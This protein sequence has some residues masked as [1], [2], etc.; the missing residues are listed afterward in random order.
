MSFGFGSPP[1]GAGPDFSH[2]DLGTVAGVQLTAATATA[3]ELNSLSDGITFADS[4]AGLSLTQNNTSLNFGLDNNV[5]Q[6]GLK[7]QFVLSAGVERG[8]NNLPNFALLGG[9]AAGVNTPM[10]ATSGSASFQ[11]APTAPAATAAP[12]PASLTLLGLGA[13]G[14]LGYGW[15]K[16]QQAA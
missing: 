5:G 9:G 13:L 14:L 16:R 15:R 1:A 4:A 6:D 10:T 7:H 12:E 8:A 11:F 3:G 2:W